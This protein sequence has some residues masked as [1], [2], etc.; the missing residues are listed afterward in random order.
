MMDHADGSW[1]WWWIVMIMM[2]DDGLWWWLMMVDNDVWWFVCIHYSFLLQ[3]KLFKGSRTK[4][5]NNGNITNK[6]MVYLYTNENNNYRFFFFKCKRSARI[7]TAK[8]FTTRRT[9]Y[10]LHHGNKTLEVRSNGDCYWQDL[11][12]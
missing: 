11:V 9:P 12:K 3:E 2:N 10:I 6:F 8:L 1:W 7:R 4:N 5:K